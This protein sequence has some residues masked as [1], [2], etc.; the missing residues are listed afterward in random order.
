[1]RLSV[2][3]VLFETSI[4]TL[5][6]DPDSML[7]RMFSG[8]H[9]V[10]KDEDGRYFIDRDGTHFRYIL[11]YLRDGNT[12]IP[13]DNQHVLDELYE[14]VQFYQLEGLLQKLE[15]IKQQGQNKIDYN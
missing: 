14:E 3:G 7:A 9:N 1:M 6:G 13:A 10:T 2:G 4:D 5:K 12:Y 11:N 15:L 8:R